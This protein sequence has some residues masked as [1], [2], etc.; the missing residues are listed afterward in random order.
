MSDTNKFFWEYLHTPIYTANEESVGVGFTST[1]GNPATNANIDMNLYYSNSGVILAG[2]HAYDSFNNPVEFWFS[3]G[4]LKF[5][6]EEVLAPFPTYQVVPAGNAA[7]S[8]TSKPS[9]ITY[10]RAQFVYPIVD[11]GV[12]VGLNMTGGYIGNDNVIVKSYNLSVSS[13]C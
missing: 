3:D 13:F 11:R 9:W 1:G 7:Y 2:L 5:N 4:I 6:P 10:K 8:G 12:G